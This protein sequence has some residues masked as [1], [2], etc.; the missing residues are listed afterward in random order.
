MSAAR[1]P[2]LSTFSITARCPRSGELGI[3]VS[4]CEPCVGW[5]VPFVRAGVGAI[6]SQA[7]SNPYFGIDGLD[8]LAGGRDAPETLA[9]M[10]ALDAPEDREQR[11]LAIVDS[12][13]KTA[14]YTGPHCQLWAGHRVDEGVVAAG[15]LLVGPETVDAML[16]RYLATPA[17]SLGERLVSA[18]EAGQAAGGDRR[19]RISA[20]LL[21]AKEGAWPW[22]DV[23][24]DSHAEPVAELRR[25]FEEFKTA[26]LDPAR[27]EM[28]APPVVCPIA[29]ARDT[30]EVI[31]RVSGD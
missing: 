4:T 24:V 13:G 7:R 30:K 29:A 9:L 10:L 26:H 12:T 2:Y 8:L 3:A 27:E 25:I 20:A 21:V 19:G 15:N 18:L 17:D 11:Q 28:I 16:N 5:I 1:W 22:I 23:R 14:A 6:A 31:D